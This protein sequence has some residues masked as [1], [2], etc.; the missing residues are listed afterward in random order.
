MDLNELGTQESVLVNNCKK[1]VKIRTTMNIDKNFKG[2]FLERHL[3][4]VIGI[5][6]IA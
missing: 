6:K 5:F 1:I 3:D 2:S 4:L